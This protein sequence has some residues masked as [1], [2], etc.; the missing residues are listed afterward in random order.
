M[1][2]YAYKEYSVKEKEFIQEMIK[3]L[4]EQDLDTQASFW[5]RRLGHPNGVV[6][7]TN[8]FEPDMH[9]KDCGED[10]G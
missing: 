5:C 6:W 7:Y 4:L 10:L 3:F 2:P 9:C 8:D 1:N